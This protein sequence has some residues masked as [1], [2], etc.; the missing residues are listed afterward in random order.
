MRSYSRLKKLVKQ[1]LSTIPKDLCEHC[2]LNRDHN[3]VVEA[4]HILH[5]FDNVFSRRLSD[6]IFRYKLLEEILSEVVDE[7][8]IVVG[9]IIGYENA[10]PSLKNLDADKENIGISYS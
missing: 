2:C 8:E 1:R 10:R 5:N 3:C 4:F 9:Y 7:T 6:Q